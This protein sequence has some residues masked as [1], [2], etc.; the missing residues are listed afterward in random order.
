MNSLSRMALALQTLFSTTADELGRACGFLQR[1]R[2]LT[3]AAFVRTLTFGWIDDPHATLE[4]FAPELRVSASALGQRCGDAAQTLLRSLLDHALANRVA[5]DPTRLPLLRRFSA[6]I[7]EDTTHVGLPADLAERFPAT[8]GTTAADNAAGMKVFVRWDLLTGRLLDLQTHPATTADVDAADAAGTLAP[9]S[10]HLADLGFFDAARRRQMNADQVFWISRVKAGLHLRLPGGI[11]K[12]LTDWLPMLSEA[13]FDGAVELV[14]SDAVA[15][16][17]V[18]RRCPR[19]IA[20]Q[21]RR[22]LDAASRRRGQIPSAEQLVLC[23]WQVLVTNLPAAEYPVPALWSLYR[24]RWQVEL[25]FRRFKQR[26]GWSFSH[27]RTGH[28]VLTE[29][30]AKL[31]GAVVVLWWVLL[32]G[33]PLAGIGHDRLFRVARAWARVVAAELATGGSAVE[34]IL[35]LLR[36]RLRRVTSQPSGSR[37]TTRKLLQR[38]ALTS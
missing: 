37:P 26:L 9:G 7:A 16:R 34:R 24:C 29:L 27:G 33:G 17:L 11:W 32:R 8:G 35:S 23:D 4:S 31:L 28:R 30:L 14:K 36:D 38:K 19:A 5:A 13:G 3:P 10:L 25:L 21:R 1:L 22:R 2:K 12:R 20:A 6:V 15:C 18:A